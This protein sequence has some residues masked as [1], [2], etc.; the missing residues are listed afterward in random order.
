MWI[1]CDI[2]FFNI[3]CQDDD[4]Q[5]GLLTVK[6]RSRKDLEDLRDFVPYTNAI[7][8]S[9][10]ADYRFR[11]KAPKHQ[12]RGGFATILNEIDY[13]KTK[14][15]LAEKHPDRQDIYLQVWGDLYAIQED[16]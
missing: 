1:V 15:K 4:L 2:G 11:I 7:E 9:E 8:E 14:P 16:R 5:K 3:V 12:V 10:K 13:P 6:A